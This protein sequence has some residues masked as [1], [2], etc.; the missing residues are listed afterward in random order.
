[1]AKFKVTQ[2][3]VNRGGKTY[4]AKD[5]VIEVDASDVSNFAGFVEIKKLKNES[6]KKDDKGM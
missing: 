4:T 1:M 2:R 3:V 6:T 5:G